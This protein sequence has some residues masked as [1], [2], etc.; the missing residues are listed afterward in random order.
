LFISYHSKLT[1]FSVAGFVNM[2]LFV[3]D[4]DSESYTG[5]SDSE[6][7]E[8]CEFTY[9]D[10]AQSILSSLDESIGKIDD[11][12]M[13]ERG[14]LHGDV[15]CH[16]SDPS[17][18]L[19]R[20]VG[21][22]MFVDLETNSG[23]IIKDVNSK[24]LSRVRSFVSGDCVVMGPW[25]GRVIRAF[26]LVTVVFSDGAKCEMLLRDS[27][28]LKPIPPIHF[29]DAP[30]F[31]YPSQRVRIA[32]PTVS[33]SGTWLSG[34]WRASRDEGVVSHV[35]VGL[36]HVNWIT[37]VTNVWGDRSSSPSNFQ[38]PKNLTLLSCFP[39][40]N[41]QLGDWCTL[42]AGRDVS[43][44][45]TDSVEPCFPS[46][47]RKPCS[48]YSQTY[49]VA[50]TKS[51]FD[52]LWQNGTA[53]LGL[54]PHNLAPVSTPGD[55]DFWPGQFVLEKLAVEEATECQRIGIVRNVDAHQRT[56]NVK[57]IIQVDND[58]ARYG[59]GATEE[60]VS[61]YELVEHP[62]FSFWTGEVVIR[63]ALNIDK[64]EADLTN[65]TMTVSRKSLDTSSGF[66]SCIG[67]VVGYKD[68]GI[69]VQW[70][71]G[72]VS[73]VSLSVSWLYSFFVF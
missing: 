4:S 61:A 25:I 48:R 41:W 59:G 63:S 5:T 13:F 58:I 22:E 11:F 66:L 49:V 20:V 18:Q 29:E 45:V 3:I 43:L 50:K 12:L 23:D 35:D 16:V 30:Y 6:D 72:V 68:E 8:D 40:A 55:H 71:S 24:Q 1:K 57:W 42:S 7:Q 19:G 2:D 69:E 65:G 53:S 14:F 21:V 31:Y 9:S 51:N 28:V 27:E 60:T 56:V 67:N 17:G 54:E 62:D 64:S 73:K 32:H 47:D 44:G 10:H 33:K 39:Y 38:D 37:S 36:V 26:D 46:E 52:V 15:V 34:S 70:A